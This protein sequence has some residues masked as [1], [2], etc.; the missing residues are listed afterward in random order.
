MSQVLNRGRGSSGVASGVVT[1]L[2]AAG[3]AVSV[4]ALAGCDQPA[5]NGA[6]S[7]SGAATTSGDATSAPIDQYEAA[8]V[9][10]EPAVQ[11]GAAAEAP[12]A[13]PAIDWNTYV[14]RFMD[15]ISMAEWREMERMADLNGDGVVD[16]TE[17][18]QAMESS[19]Q[20]FAEANMAKYDTNGDGVIDEDERRAAGEDLREQ[21]G[22]AMRQQ[23][24]A[25]RNAK[26]DTDGDGVLS[27]AELAAMEAREQQRQ[28]EREARR[29][30]FTKRV[31]TDGDGDVSRDEW[32]AFGE[33]EQARRQA[34]QIA[35]FDANGDGQLDDAER[36][37]QQA[38][39]REQ[40]AQFRDTREL[41]MFQGLYDDDGDGKVG[42]AEFDLFLQRHAANHKYADVNMDD[43]VD[44]AD[45]TEFTR[46]MGQLEN[47]D[48]E[49]QNAGFGRFGG[50]G[51]GGGGFGGGRGGRGG[52]G[53]DGGQRGGGPGQGGAGQG[54]G[55]QAGGGGGG[56][57]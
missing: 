45:L 27:E 55:G 7:T 25:M 13:R 1:V 48:L 32:R 50:G 40:M 49:A 2:A 34:E 19:A 23:F 52:G 53:G 51:F 29:A 9:V 38:E 30:E 31:D 4:L 35:K 56:G 57:N 3:V 26:F 42:T 37:A 5:G 12:A 22:Q 54:G 47:T 10:D 17:L 21:V 15:G 39:A 43:Q 8:V 16:F 36:T 14:Q 20:A 24:E 41:R 11:V 33:A 6:V 44:Q 28:A 18:R 46:M